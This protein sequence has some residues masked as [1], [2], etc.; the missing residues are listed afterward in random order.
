[1]KCL[2]EQVNELR[3]MI[4]MM[5]GQ[6]EKQEI[7][8]VENDDSRGGENEESRGGENEESR[9]GENEES[10]GGENEE[11]RGGENEESRGSESKEGRGGE[12]EESRGNVW[13]KASKK[14]IDGKR[15]SVQHKE[16]KRVS[17]EGLPGV[18]TAEVDER[19]EREHSV[20]QERSFADVVSQGKARKAWI[21]MGDSIIRKVDKIV[22][23]GEDI[24]VCLPGTKI[25]DVAEKAGQIMGGGMGGAVPLHVGTTNAEKE[26][27]LAIIGKYR[28]LVKTLRGRQG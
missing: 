13:K 18:K 19:R 27:T 16:N 4:L 17:G 24:M 28:R 25:E 15:K 21:F 12:N 6:G 9:G 1:M 7:R 20:R 2:R 22:N 10:R 3:H 11:S 14:N 23:R 8:G 5:T 26:G